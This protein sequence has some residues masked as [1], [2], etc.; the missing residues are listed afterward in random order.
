MSS[1]SRCV[2]V[3]PP[4]S[5]APTRVRP[6]FCTNS[7]RRPGERHACQCRSVGAGRGSARCPQWRCPHEHD[8]MPTLKSDASTL[9]LTNRQKVFW[10]EHGYTKGD[11][12]DYYRDIASVML[13]YLKDRP[14]SMHRHVD[15]HQGKEF[16]QRI[17]RDRPPWV[18]TA[19]VPTSRRTYERDFVLPGLADSALAGELR[20]HRVHPVGLTRRHARLARLLVIDLDPQDVPFPRVV[21]VAQAVHKLLDRIGADNYYKTSG[22]RGL[23]VCVPLGGQYLFNQAKMLS[24][25]LAHLIHQKFPCPPGLHLPRYHAQRPRQ[26]AGGTV[27]RPSLARRDSRGTAQVVGGAAHARSRQVH[28]Q[29]HRAAR[30]PARRLVGAGAGAGNRPGAAHD[31]HWPRRLECERW[32]AD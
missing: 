32:R 20:L 26:G 13:P 16:W 3:S 14:Q 28:D 8:T 15:G 31:Q 19:K 25:I 1:P 9:V 18:Q 23:H 29:E 27:L 2:I 12:L 4:L 22:K 7:V 21:E 10:P 5:L 30:G 24:Q 11:L 6:F 17:S